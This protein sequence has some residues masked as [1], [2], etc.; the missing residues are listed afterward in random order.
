VNSN[1]HPHSLTFFWKNESDRRNPTTA[2]NKKQEEQEEERKI[3]SNQTFS[4]VIPHL[5]LLALPSTAHK[6]DR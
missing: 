6:A 1:Y 2:L 4:L 3:K 5:I